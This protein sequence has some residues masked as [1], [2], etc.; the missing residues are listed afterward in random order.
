MLTT[1]QTNRKSIAIVC[2]LG[3]VRFF[4][5]LIL[6][7]QRCPN[8]PPSTSKSVSLQ[9]HQISPTTPQQHMRPPRKIQTRHSQLPI[10]PIHHPKA[11]QRRHHP[12][13]PH[14]RNDPIPRQTR[15]HL[16]RTRP[17]HHPPNPSPH[18][19]NRLLH[20]NPRDPRGH[21]ARGRG[22]RGRAV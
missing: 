2:L 16:P 20:D 17:R 8:F 6:A 12:L 22:A 9:D 3:T 7:V 19:Q 13:D 5:I 11:P 18:R 1:S 15:T 4:T 10:R 14:P 21:G